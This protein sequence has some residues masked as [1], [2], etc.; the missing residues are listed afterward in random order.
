MSTRMRSIG[1][2]IHRLNM[3]FTT[4]KWM[5]YSVAEPPIHNR[6]I[7]LL[8]QPCR[9]I[10]TVITHVDFMFHFHVN[11][12]NGEYLTFTQMYGVY[13]HIQLNC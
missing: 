3:S 6:I 12:L 11:W 9:F 1:I 10:C 5:L 7:L 2:G 8:P 4:V 13:Y